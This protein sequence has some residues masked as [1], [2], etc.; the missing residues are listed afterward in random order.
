MNIS[1]L[2]PVNNYDLVAFV[3]SL[4]IGMENVPEFSEILIGD[5]GSYE[6]YRNKYLP[7]RQQTG[8]IVSER[9]SDAL[10]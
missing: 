8:V 6:D 10:P 9:I 4:R 2:I 7:H 1:I 3:H 5:D